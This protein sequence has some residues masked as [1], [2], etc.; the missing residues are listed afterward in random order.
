VERRIGGRT[1]CEI[2]LPPGAGPVVLRLERLG[3]GAGVALV[4]D[5]AATASAASERLAS[6]AVALRCWLAL[7]AWSALALGL[8]AWFSAPTA[9]AGTLAIAV[10]TWM[11]E[12]AP[13]WLPGR[14]LG[15][16]L[17]AVGEGLVPA[18]PTLPALG[19]AAACVV[20]GLGLGAA[21]LRRWRRG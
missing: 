4:G 12:S 1:S 15:A 20:L 17:V 9:A 5:V 3:P 21:G 14:D 19:A 8:G 18:W 10:A 2:E 6:V 16:A 11:A 13:A 7:C